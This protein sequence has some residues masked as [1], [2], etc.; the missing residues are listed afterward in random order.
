MV[1]GYDAGKALFVGNRKK[2]PRTDCRMPKGQRRIREAASERS[3]SQKKP[4][5]SI[6]DFTVVT[7]LAGDPGSREQIQRAYRRYYW[8]GQYVK[9][10]DVVEVAC[11]VGQGLG[12][13][14]TLAKSVR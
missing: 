8:D 12:Y 6:P 1:L 2:V 5:G 14:A 11:G 13:L 3:S 9:G 10:A 4:M 7:E